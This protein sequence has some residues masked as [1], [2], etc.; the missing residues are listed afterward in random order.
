MAEQG[1]VMI[2]GESYLEEPF[3]L[4]RNIG[5]WCQEYISTQKK[6]LQI[7]LELDYVN[8]SSFR[9]LLDYLKNIKALQDK[10]HDI[11]V[12]WRY[13]EKDLNDIREEGEDLAFDAGIEFNFVAY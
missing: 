6:P 2:K 12:N 5:D 13:P 1:Q 3:E 8:S 7:D 10:G 11:S 4:Y 9:A